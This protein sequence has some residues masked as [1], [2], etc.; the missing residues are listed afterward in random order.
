MS[1]TINVETGAAPQGG[2]EA[3]VCAVPAS[4][5]AF[6]TAAATAVS[7]AGSFI[8]VEVEGTKEKMLL[9]LTRIKS[10]V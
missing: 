2:T 7:A 4:K 5:A 3:Y 9:N 10:V 1:V 8:E 6:A